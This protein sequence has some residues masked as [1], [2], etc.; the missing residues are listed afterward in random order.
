MTTTIIDNPVFR[1]I[2]NRFTKKCAVCDV[3]VEANQGYACEHKTGWATYCEAHVPVKIETERAEITKE[4]HIYFPYHPDAVS[5][6]KSLYYSSWQKEG[7]FW[8]VSIEPEHI[9]RVIQVGR[10]LGLKIADEL[11]EIASDVQE[12]AEEKVEINFD[13]AGL[14]PY[15]VTGAAFLANKYRCLLG[16]E[17]GTGKTVQTL[18]S[19]PKDI[20]TLVVCPASL[21]FNWRD[22]TNKW[23]PDLT[24]IVLNGRKSFRLPEAR[25][26]VIVNY[27]ILPQDLNDIQKKDFVLV[28]DEV[29][30]CKNY[31]AKR[32]RAVKILSNIAKKTVGLTGT[33]LMNRPFDLYGVL[34]SLHLENEVFGSWIGFLRAFNGYKNEW[35]GYTFGAVSPLV[36]ELLRRV[37]LRRRREEVLP[38]LPKKSYTTI[39]VDGVSKSLQKKLDEV[40][41]EV[42]LL[43]EM[44]ELPPFEM[45]AEIRAALAES[46]IEAMLEI[47]ENHEEEEIPLVVFSA[48][49][50]PID[51]LAQREGWATITGSTKPE[52]RQGIVRKFQ[53]GEL[54]G[55][56]LTIAAG[57]VGLTLT[58]AWKALF[59]DLDWTPALNSQ[60]EDRICRIGQTKP[61]EIVRMVSDHV[62]DRHIHELIAEKI[63]LFNNAIDGN[64]GNV[65]LTISEGE[66]DEQYA[67]RMAALQAEFDAKQ[68]EAEALNEKARKDAAKKK[69][70]MI[71]ERE[72]NKVTNGGKKKFKMPEFTPVLVNSIKDN[73]S[74]MLGVC[75]GARERDNVG[76]NKPD[77]M[78]SRWLYA[79]GLEETETLQAAYLMLL[80]YPRQ[81]RLKLK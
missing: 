58:R 30:L 23:R 18:A 8:R 56:G 57:G 22:E 12:E 73:L 69:V 33:P 46:R 81:V 62:L 64:I 45:F 42:E 54:K 77:A 53:S 39:T 1:T 28:C 19:L 49:R 29:H 41:D 35:G 14:F 50:A 20:G 80:R 21:K 61:C 16:D 48:H 51:T 7:K 63:D 24:P 60:A 2:R 27:D 52:D 34:S 43:L 67:V 55:V 4:G 5:L 72:M 17:M 59:V 13:T 31:K 68:V 3:A 75:D 32:S 25:E 65:K 9:N 40:Y 47:V 10:Q 15:Q 44:K 37:M 38:D 36:P 26:V 71:I 76:F 79:A 70:G 6:V 11:L 78:L 66:T 74:K